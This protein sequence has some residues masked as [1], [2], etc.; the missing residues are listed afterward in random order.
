MGVAF[1]PQLGG[2]PA[3]F[4]GTDRTSLG[5]VDFSGESRIGAAALQF[6][7]PLPSKPPSA[8]LKATA[9]VYLETDDYSLAQLLILHQAHI[10]KAVVVVVVLV[11]RRSGSCKTIS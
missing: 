11:L 7:F 5:N 2:S 9:R 3:K 6:P 4:S 1:P 8:F 10:N